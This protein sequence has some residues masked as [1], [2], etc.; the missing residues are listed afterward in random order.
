MLKSELD[1]RCT[2]INNLHALIAKIQ[3]DKTKLSKKIS[4]LL[5]NGKLERKLYLNIIEKC[6]FIVYNYQKKSW[7]ERSI[8]YATWSEHQVA[9]EQ[10]TR[11]RRVNST[12]TWRTSKASEISTSER[13]KRFRSSW[14]R[15]RRRVTGIVALIIITIHAQPRN[16]PLRDYPLMDDSRNQCRRLVNSAAR[17]V[18]IVRNRR[19]L[20]LSS[21]NNRLLRRSRS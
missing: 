9:D 16:H 19:R 18:P 1:D 8:H 10:P 15:R 3:E 21:S 4:N 5:E 13:L 14:N 12:R 6:I 11:H 2:D 7:F 17:F 20:L